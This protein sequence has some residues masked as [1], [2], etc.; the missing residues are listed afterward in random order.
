MIVTFSEGTHAALQKTSIYSERVAI[1]QMKGSI[2]GK[3]GDGGT[4][5]GKGVC[6]HSEVR[7]SEQCFV[8][9]CFCV[10]Y[11]ELVVMA[12]IRVYTHFLFHRCTCIYAHLEK[13][14]GGTTEE[15]NQVRFSEQCFVEMCFCVH[16][17][18]LVVMAHIRVY[19]HFLFHRC[20]CI[21]AHLEKM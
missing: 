14:Y 21:Y 5:K 1:Q 12:H 17:L 2:V 6:H 13:M 19:T 7:Y 3:G 16:Y 4:G 11:L 9:M 18:E 15:H 20:T 10:H 8:E